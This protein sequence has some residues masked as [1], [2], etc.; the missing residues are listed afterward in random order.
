[1]SA[2]APA[3]SVAIVHELQRKLETF[4]QTVHENE[5]MIEDLR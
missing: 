2:S 4:E 5:E 3:G 1:M